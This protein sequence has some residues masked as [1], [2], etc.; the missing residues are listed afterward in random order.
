M[1]QYFKITYICYQI[2]GEIGKFVMSESDMYG[3]EEIAEFEPW[4]DLTDY[5]LNSHDDM[6]SMYELVVRAINEKTV[7]FETDE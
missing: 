1:L 5:D 7:P 4:L 6:Y 2:I 3:S